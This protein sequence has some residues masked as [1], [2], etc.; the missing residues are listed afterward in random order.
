MFSSVVEVVWAM[1]YVPP[2]EKAIDDFMDPMEYSYE[3]LDDSNRLSS[4]YPE[5]M[6]GR[7]TFNSGPNNFYLI[8]PP[9]PSSTKA[10]YESA[11]DLQKATDVEHIENTHVAE[12]TTTS[13]VDISTGKESI[14]IVIP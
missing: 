2:V 4:N 1:Y 5:K 3:L 12:E 7:R 8:R 13:V 14:P 11:N 9:N 10:F 6:N